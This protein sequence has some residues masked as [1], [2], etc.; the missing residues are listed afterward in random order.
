LLPCTWAPGVTPDQE[1]KPQKA[2]QMADWTVMVYVDGDNTLYL[3]ALKDMNEM[4]CGK[5]SPSINVVVLID[6]PGHGDTHILLIQQNEDMEEIRSPAVEDGGRVI[7]DYES[8][9]GDPQTLADFAT[10]C[11]EEYPAQKYGLIVWGH[12]SGI[13]GYEEMGEGKP[14]S[15]LRGICWD[16]TDDNYL[17]IPELREALVAI[18][19]D[20]KE[21]FAV[22][23]FDVCFMAMMEILYEVSPYASYA[24][25]SQGVEH[26]EGWNYGKLLSLLSQ[27]P[28]MDGKCLARGMVE[29]YPLE[30]Y[31]ISKGKS[32]LLPATLSAVDLALMPELADTLDELCSSVMENMDDYVESIYQV[33]KKVQG[34]DLDYLGY[35]DLD[36]FLELL[37]VAVAKDGE[38]ADRAARVKFLLDDAVIAEAHHLTDYADGVS[39]YFPSE[40]WKYLNYYNGRADFLSFAREHNWDEFILSYYDAL[41]RQSEEKV[42]EEKAASPSVEHSPA[43]FLEAALTQSVSESY[44][45]IEM[46]DKFSPHTPRIYCCVKLSDAPAGTKIDWQWKIVEA[47]G[48]KNFELSHVDLEL[49]VAQIGPGWAAMSWI[50][51][52]KFDVQAWPVGSYE[53]EVYLEGGRVIN[54]PF[55][56]APDPEDTLVT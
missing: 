30:R 41:A 47:N 13:S 43:K 36:R 52:E 19:Q 37:K 8:D 49:S 31:T 9:M 21:K 25:A 38:M 26:R 17:T 46:A 40:G 22:I 45:P 29:A 24:V 4:E 50:Y 51:P 34:F 18:T 48:M 28:S 55:T 27:D 7:Q 6:G 10:W 53:V 39:I 14:G 3:D 12:G 42:A 5:L 56:V 44:V 2:E 35:I 23:G 16:G 20:G 15:A 1:A 54:L 32:I 11:K 33:R